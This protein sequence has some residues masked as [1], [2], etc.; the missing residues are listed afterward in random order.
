MLK[1]LLIKLYY[2]PESAFAWANVLCMVSYLG[3]DSDRILRANPIS[4]HNT[5]RKGWL[6]IAA[7]ILLTKKQLHLQIQYRHLN[8]PFG[9]YGGNSFSHDSNN[10]KLNTLKYFFFFRVA[11]TLTFTIPKSH[12][13][14]PCYINHLQNVERSADKDIADHSSLLRTC[15]GYHHICDPLRTTAS[16]EFA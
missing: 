7:M 9:I 12:F 2:I 3:H 1:D 16:T 4:H 13:L 5:D 10:T 6:I 15:P 11:P 14:L 8:S